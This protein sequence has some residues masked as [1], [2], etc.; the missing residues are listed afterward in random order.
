MDMLMLAVFI[1]ACFALNLAP[2]PNNLLAL[3]NGKTYGI[4]P[5]VMAGTGRLFAFMLMITLVATGLS[6]VLYTSEYVFMIIKVVGACYL[7]WLAYQTWNASGKIKEVS[8]NHAYNQTTLMKQEFLLA[9]GNPKAI[10][11]FTAFLPQFISVSEPVQPQFLLLGSL[12]LILEWCA[13][14]L[15]ALAGRYLDNVLSNP[16]SNRVFNRICASFY[17]TAGG[18]ILLN[19]K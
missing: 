11:I 1:P 9:A 17:A 2:G 7:F 16:T 3:N 19:E 6:A 15:Y 10:L 13:I 8:V 5:A 18:G 12:F 4:K 14:T